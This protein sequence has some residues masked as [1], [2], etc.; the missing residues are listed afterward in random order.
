MFNHSANRSSLILL[1]ALLCA[2]WAPVALAQTT[3]FTYQG[4]FNDNGNPAN[5]TYDFQ[6]RLFDAAAGGTQQG[7]ALG[8]ND[9]Q[10]T[11]GLFKATM[12]FG[13]AAFTGGNRWLEISVRPGA[14]TGAYTTLNPRQ[15]LTSS[16]YS[17]RSL[18]ATSADGLSVACVNC[19][20]STQIGSLPGGSPSYIQNSSLTQPAS[21][22]NISGNGTAGGTLSGNAVNA[23]TQFNLNAI[24]VLSSGGTDNLFAGAGAG[25]ANPSGTS[26]AFFGVNAGQATST[27]GSNTFLGKSAG[28]ANTAGASN[29]FTSNNAGITNNTGNNDTFIGFSAGASNTLGSFN[30]ALGW[31]S[32]VGSGNQFA[33]AL[34]ARAEAACSNCLVLGAVQGVNGATAS[35]NIGIGTNTPT[36]RLHVV[37]DTN[38]LG[39]LSFSGTL[40]GSGA[41]LTALNASNITTGT[42]ATARGGTGLSAPG[43]A[44]NYL[45][46]DGTGWTSSALLGSDIPGGSTNYIQNSTT[47]QSSSNFNISGNGFLGGSLGIGTSTITPGRR[48]TVQTSTGI[49]LSHTNGAVE[50]GTY[51]NSNGG[52]LQTH[53]NH[54]M[55]FATN[56][57][58]AQMTLTPAGNLGIGTIA[59]ADKLSVQTGSASCGLTHTDGV[60]T[61]GTW[62]GSFNNS[63]AGWLGTKSN[64]PLHLFATNNGWGNTGGAPTMTVS[65]RN[66]GIGTTAPVGDLQVVANPGGKSGTIQVG[67]QDAWA[68]GNFRGILFGDANCGPFGFPAPCTYIGE[69]DSDNR[70]VL[71][72]AQI[73]LK[74]DNAVEPGDDGQ[75]DLGTQ[76]K[77]WQRVFA[78][79]GTIQTS[80]ARLKQNIVNLRYGLQ[81]LLQLRPVTFQW[82]DNLNGRTQL[83]LIAQEVEKL[84][85]E[86][87]ERSA[88]PQAPLGMNYSNLL[89]LVI[90]AIQEQQITLDQKDA[91]LALLKTENAALK[92][93]NARLEAR[94]T[95]LEQSLQKLLAPNST[96]TESVNPPRQQR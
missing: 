5:G 45:R 29:T 57:S 36:S 21:N 40:N 27:G 39:N 74:S 92:E 24:R 55:F 50:I 10:V 15:E 6:F 41:N 95:A 93:Q 11:N 13:V 19:V 3:A 25:A 18:L 23:T 69:E 43:A 63:P 94:L 87:V 48:L 71:R 8:F 22:F 49:G 58:S 33:T 1:T 88:D 82:K 62:V 80:D 60:V 67:S 85:P 16:P 35:T 68:P 47:L 17:V 56:N 70:L 12:D 53:S 34:G 77:R 59:P 64:H 2:L 96:T 61:I 84:I 20:T 30:T 78:T 14:S 81:E 7:P 51:V 54:P 79:N 86:A 44:G 28:V 46:S 52:W 89:P 73:V 90:K 42:L 9:V 83:G 66:V 76:T 38:L 72:G 32:L 75:I 91:A 37:G 26:N 65:W 31:G 4:Q